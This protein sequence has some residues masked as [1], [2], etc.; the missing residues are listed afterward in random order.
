MSLKQGK[1]WLLDEANTA[2]AAVKNE[3]KAAEAKR[4]IAVA[5]AREELAVAEKALS[6]N[7]VNDDN[8]KL[9]ET[10]QM[11]QAAL[12]QA[13]KMYEPERDYVTFNV[14][15][16]GSFKVLKTVSALESFI[17]KVNVNRGFDKQ[18]PKKLFPAPLKTR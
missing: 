8:K 10:V 6:D 17:K 16:D 11:K 13:R 15:N 14:P 9:R 7:K 2:L 1:Q 3:A 5:K 4:V 18:S 12:I